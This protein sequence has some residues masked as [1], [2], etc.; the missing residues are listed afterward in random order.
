MN[1]NSDVWVLDFGRNVVS[2]FTTD[3]A[4]DL[5]PIWSP[6][7]RRIVFSSTR[8]GVLDL[9]QK[10]AAGAG[11]EELLLS[12]AQ[13]KVAS[14]WS[15]DGRFLLYVS[16]D[17]KMRLDLWALP[18]EGD[19]KPFPVA[20]TNFDERGGQFSPDGKWIA[21]Q[22]GESGR[23][24]IYIQ[25]FPGPGGKSLVSTTGG[26]LAHWRRDGKELF[27]IGL[28]NRLMAVPIQLASN[29]QAVEAGA[30]VPLF[31]TRIGDPAQAE[32]YMVS[33]SGQRF[34]ISTLQ[35]K[36]PRPSRSS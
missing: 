21:Y 4:D 9:Y 30:P 11:S 22:S 18:L 27:Y 31:A 33:S 29:G 6:D 2:R 26:V 19:R 14:D 15:F 1:Q 25:P 28:D 13:H 34:L 23:L 36:P 5:C 20:Q 12:T 3:A 10:P 35:N 32:M 17:P 8:K 7:G 24:E 16:R